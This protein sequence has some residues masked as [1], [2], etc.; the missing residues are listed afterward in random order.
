MNP[1]V[2][3]SSALVATAIGLSAAGLAAIPRLSVNLKELRKSGEQGFD[4][5]LVTEYLIA[6]GITFNE[7]GAFT[8]G[9][10]LRGPDATVKTEG[11]LDRRVGDFAA[12]LSCTEQGWM[13]EFQ[14]VRLPSKLSA[15]VE[16]DTFAPSPTHQRLARRTRHRSLRG[17]S[18]TAHHVFA[19]GRS[20]AHH[21]ELA[22]QRFPSG[23]GAGRDRRGAGG[24]RRRA[25]VKSRRR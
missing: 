25:A 13:Y 11:G 4:S 15:M 9:W 7:D 1:F 3:E 18:P 21:R 12:A 24:A 16:P 23:E 6:P 17:R 19:S 2:V 14:R 8:T 20:V 22:H 10:K 5:L